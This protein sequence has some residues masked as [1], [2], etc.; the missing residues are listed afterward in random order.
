M[1]KC[2]LIVALILSASLASAGTLDSLEESATK[3]Q[4]SKQESSSSSSSDS[5]SSS[6]GIVGS[7]IGD[8]IGRMIEA[9]IDA[10]AEAV[11]SA[12]ARGGELS[13]KRFECSSIDDECAWRLDQEGN[14][15][16]NHFREPGDATLPMFKISASYLNAKDDIGGWMGYAEAGYGAFAISHEHNSLYEKEDSLHIS[17]VL[18]HYRMTFSN[19]FSLGVAIG[20]GGLKGNGSHSGTVVAMPLRMKF[21]EGKYA[22]EYYPVSYGF[23]GLNLSSNQLT[24]SRHFN[25]YAV[26]IGWKSYATDEVS[27]EGPFAGVQFTY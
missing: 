20:G 10:M 16:P 4:S 15:Y 27:I 2:A 19:D 13:K 22:F 23:G 24:F 6:G 12:I 21:G 25:R 1:D 5:S 26:N 11:T 18:A 14:Y 9:A 8:L 17:N 7:I 3:P